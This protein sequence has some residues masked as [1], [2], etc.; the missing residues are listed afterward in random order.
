MSVLPRRLL[1]RRAP[2]GQLALLGKATLVDE[3]ANG[4]TEMGVGIG[5]QLPPPP[6]AIPSG[7]AQHVMQLLLAALGHTFHIAA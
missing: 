2:R 5:D 7:L 3:H 6:K 1:H 4:I